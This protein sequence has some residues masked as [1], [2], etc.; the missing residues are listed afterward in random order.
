[1]NT[2]RHINFIFSEKEKEA[3]TIV[4]SVLRDV[5]DNIEE[6][7]N[8]C[9]IQNDNINEEYNVLGALE[10]INYYSSNIGEYINGNT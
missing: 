3:L 5:S 7:Y 10:E 4:A 6:G 9:N 8:E 2:E 1:M